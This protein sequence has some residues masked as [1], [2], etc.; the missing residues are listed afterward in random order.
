MSDGIA[1][2]LTTVFVN[3]LVTIQFLG[4]CPLLGAS[5]KFDSAIGIAVGTA[6][7]LT[8]ASA[9]SYIIESC[10]LSPL[11]LQYLRLV[12]FIILIVSLVRISEIIIRATQ[13]RLHA[14]LPIFGISVPLIITNCAVLGVALI[15]VREAHSFLQSIF[16][17][18]G[19][20][21]GFALVLIL[22]AAIQRQQRASVVPKVFRG[23]AINMITAGL[24]SLA[25]M[26]FTG[27]GQ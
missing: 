17:G 8:L 23:A 22:F 18:F 21:I 19:A 2:L 7:V 4:L 24:L 1:I 26:G 15:N 13:P 14:L 11:D 27:M 10:I 6:F 9:V 16:F 3:N 5:Q 12:I 20:A 25:F